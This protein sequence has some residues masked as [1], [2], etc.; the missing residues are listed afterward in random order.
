MGACLVDDRAPAVNQPVSPG[1]TPPNT[2]QFTGLL[3]ESSLSEGVAHPLP[4]LRL[5][6]VEPRT[7]VSNSDCQMS[8][9]K[10]V[11]LSES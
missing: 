8:L 5:K 10:S 4:Q 6:L 11:A 2:T 1:W 3:T 9:G 7:Q